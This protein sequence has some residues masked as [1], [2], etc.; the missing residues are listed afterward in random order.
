MIASTV[1]LASHVLVSS[2]KLL[3]PVAQ[4]LEYVVPYYSNM[5]SK[6]DF[7]SKHLAK[8][9]PLPP[10]TGKLRVYNMRF[11]PYAQRTILALNAKKIDYEVV[12]INLVNK[13]EWLFDKSGFGKVPSVEIEEN[14]CIYES[15]ITVEYIDEVF[16]ER[17]LLPKEPARKAFDKIIIEAMSPVQ[18]IFYKSIRQPEAITDAMVSDYHKALL[19]LQDQLKSRGTKFLSGNEPGY[20]DYMIWPWFERILMLKGVNG[21]IPIEGEKFKLILTYFDDMFVDPAVSQYLL[22]EEVVQKFFAAYS[23]GNINNYDIY[24]ENL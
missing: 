21:R 5:T 23:S 15:L 22:P 3:S 24:L 8:G 14:V 12:N 4:V 9:D 6:I 11:C 16:P 20:V 10:Y 19:F 18:Q 1:S 17:P 13:P 2:W 7:N